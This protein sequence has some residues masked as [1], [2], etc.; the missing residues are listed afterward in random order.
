MPAFTVLRGGMLSTVQDLGRWG[1]QHLGVPVAGPMDWYS[2]RL[3]NRLVG[4][5]DDAA[6]IEMTLIGPELVTDADVICAAAGGAFEVTAGQQLVPLHAPFTLMRGQRMRFRLCGAGARAT[7]AVRGGISVPAVMGSRSTSLISR[8][9]PFGGRALAAGDVLPIGRPSMASRP[10]GPPLPI[11]QGGARVRVLWGPHAARFTP[12]A[13]RAF[14]TSR[15][16]VTPESNR[17]GYR[18]SG[19]ALAFGASGSI[20]MLSD[21]TPIGSLQVPPSGLPILLMADRQTTGGYPKIATVITA[22]L[23]LAGQLA[24]GDWIEFVPVTRAAAIDAIRRRDA[25]LSTVPA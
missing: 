9:G 5:P 6:A 14:H 10:T 15:Y 18:L 13:V 23:P 2:H 11:N 24:P 22:D 21:A 12:E 25:A 8:V 3:A 4:N 19:T 20:D 7:V 17:M 16:E 1:L